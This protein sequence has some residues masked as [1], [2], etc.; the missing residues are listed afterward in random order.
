M[1]DTMKAA[2]LTEYGKPLQMQQIEIPQPQPGEV[3]VKLESCGVCHTD[4]H[5]WL[6]EHQLPGPL[7]AILGHEG[8]GKVVL[9]GNENSS[10]RIG[11][12]VGIGYVYGA[13]G[14]CRECLTGH[15]THCKDVQSTGVHSFG[16]FA[17]YVCI[18]EDWATRIPDNLSS[19]NAAPLL[20]AGVAAY[21]AVRKAALEP[22]ELAV[23]FGAG[24]LGFYAIQSAKLTGAKVVA[25][26]IDQDKLNKALEI[27]ADYVVRADQDPVAFIQNLGGADACFNFAPV[28][29]TWKQMLKAVSPCARIVLVALPN[30]ELTFEAPDIIETG[31]TVRGSADG[32]RQELRQLMA[33]ADQGLIHTIAESVPFS[34]I[35]SAMD[36]VAKG[37]ITGRI[38][39][40]MGA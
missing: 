2:V 36:R 18:R 4:V 6:G 19:I 8:T 16:C 1:K 26:D 27:G 20:C 30:K 12:R 28:T 15:E 9:L 13:C 38:V 5:F 31:L 22:G 17:E 37:Q 40:D 35:N 23:V 3:L 7:P 10:L 24:G 21:S 33:L 11:D 25:V 39:L 32:T 34:E 14:Q 29:S